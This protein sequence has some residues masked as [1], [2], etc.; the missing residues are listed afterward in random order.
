[1]SCLHATYA[2]MSKHYTAVAPI[3]PSVCDE[4]RAV[5]R[6]LTFCPGRLGPPLGPLAQASDASPYGYGVCQS[7]WGP[8]L[9]RLS[10]APERVAVFNGSPQA[11]VSTPSQ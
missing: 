7:E 6:L 2:F 5:C 10:A 8:A 11:L 9:Q 1:M 4:L 3:W